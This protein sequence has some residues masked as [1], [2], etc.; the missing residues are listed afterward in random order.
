MAGRVAA[1]KIFV[2]NLPWTVGHSELRQYFSEFGHVSSANVVFNRDTGISRG[3]GFV[4]FGNKSALTAVMDRTN[5]QLEG[6]QISV[7][8]ASN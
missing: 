2:G 6:S 3:F 7:Q 5:H 8:S 1:R 4:V